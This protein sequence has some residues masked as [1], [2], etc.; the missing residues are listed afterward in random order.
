[1][2][3]S[4]D[5]WQWFINQLLLHTL[6]SS[7]NFLGKILFWICVYLSLC[8]DHL[9]AGAHGGRRRPR[10]PFWIFR[11]LSAAL[12]GCSSNLSL[13]GNEWVLL[14][15]ET[16]TLN[17]VESVTCRWWKWER[18]VRFYRGVRDIHWRCH[19]Q[20]LVHGFRL[21]CFSAWWHVGRLWFFLSNHLYMSRPWSLMSR[22]LSF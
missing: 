22:S 3:F 1:M 8:V 15:T 19:G 21:E 16:S 5:S 4:D 20:Y 11:Q 18:D 17:S 9:C 10:G 12:H 13:Q 7:V 14:T 6:I 2:R